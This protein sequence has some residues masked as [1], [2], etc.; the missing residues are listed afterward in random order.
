MKSYKGIL[1][2]S[3]KYIGYAIL[4]ACSLI[5]ISI[6]TGLFI[7][8]FLDKDCDNQFIAGCMSAGLSE[9]ACK[10]KIY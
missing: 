6:M 7:Y 3:G 8:V 9:E 10:N 2:K 4:F 5:A 1:R